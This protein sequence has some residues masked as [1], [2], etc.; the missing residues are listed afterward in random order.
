M[1]S[2]KEVAIKG[3]DGT[4]SRISFE[5]VNSDKLGSQLPSYYLPQKIQVE[6]SADGWVDIPNGD[7]QYK[8]IQFDSI[9]NPDNKIIIS[10]V[11]LGTAADSNQLSLQ[12]IEAYQCIDRI[13]INNGVL[14]LYCYEDTPSTSFS[15]QFIVFNLK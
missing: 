14:E 8:T 7:G 15:I 1:A 5:A 4:V 3:A 6:V 2:T 9:T 13:V 11:Y 10:D 12:Q